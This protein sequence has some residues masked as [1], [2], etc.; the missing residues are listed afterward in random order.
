MS[1]FDAGAALLGG[2]VSFFSPCVLPLLPAYQG[3]LIGAVPSDIQRR[4]K[5]YQALLLR[6]TLAFC[7]GFSAVFMLFGAAAAGLTDIGPYRRPL[8]VIGGVFLI[9][10]GAAVSGLLP[11]PNFLRA[12]HVQLGHGR[13][14]IG[15]AGA[16]AAFACGWTPCNG[17]VLAAILSLAADGNALHGMELLAIYSL[18]LALPFIAAAALTLPLHRYLRG[19]M[20]S[21]IA[22]ALSV[23]LGLK[24]LFSD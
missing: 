16:G 3:F 24:M 11:T 21:A 2:A 4:P 9:V 7:A 13:S 5:V 6:R 15:A 22:G 12:R 8:Q 14:S 19:R 17:P 18:G 23:L 20:I 10:S 1:G